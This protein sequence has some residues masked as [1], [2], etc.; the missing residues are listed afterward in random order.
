LLSGFAPA[1]PRKCVSISGAN[2]ALTIGD[3]RFL[4]DLC[5]ADCEL[6]TRTWKKT[7][8]MIETPDIA[9]D[10]DALDYSQISI[11][12]EYIDANGHMNVGY[13]TVLF[14]RALDLAWARLGIYS[15]Q[16][17]ARGY[18]SFALQ[19]HL[20]YK[21]ELRLGDALDFDI[22]LLDYDAKRVH[23][24]MQMLHRQERW[25]AATCEQL[26]ICMNMHTR[27]STAWPA[28]ALV[29]VAAL[30]AAHQD[31]PRPAEVGQAIGIRRRAAT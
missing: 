8:T 15:G 14:D 29:D 18:S 26:S 11:L 30:H 20:H 17:L 6:E 1:G 16:I 5:S 10:I 7:Q 3:A 28:E 23:Y 12:P 2:S 21:R 24:L 25:V 13:Y 4:G 19:S 27:R 31:R 22:L 9:R